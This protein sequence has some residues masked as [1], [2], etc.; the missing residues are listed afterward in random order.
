MNTQVSQVTRYSPYERVYHNEPPDLFN[1]KP[2]QI[3]SNVT[4][5]Q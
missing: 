5:E 4:A 2:G 1:Y 3:G